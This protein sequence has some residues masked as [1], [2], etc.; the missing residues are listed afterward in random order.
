[1]WRGCRLE[2]N[3]FDLV[4]KESKKIEFASISNDQIVPIGDITSFG[5]CK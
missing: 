3:L 5:E 2:P 1:V 4:E